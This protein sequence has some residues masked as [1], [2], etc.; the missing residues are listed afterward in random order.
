[1]ED[2]NKHSTTDQRNNGVVKDGHPIFYKVDVVV[3]SFVIIMN[4]LEIF[5]LKCLKKKLRIYE[6]FLL[7][8][9]CSDLLFGFTYLS[10]GSEGGALSSLFSDANTVAAITQS[11]FLL[12]LL[13]SIF[14]LNAIALDRLWA[15]C[16]PI[17]HNVIV[18]KPRVRIF[19]GFVWMGCAILISCLVTVTLY[20]NTFDIPVEAPVTVNGTKDNHNTTSKL[21][22]MSS[23]NSSQ[24]I[25]QRTIDSDSEDFN[26]STSSFR[27]KNNGFKMIF[28]NEMQNACSYAVIIS[29]VLLFLT[30]GYII[31]YIRSI[32]RNLGESTKKVDFSKHKKVLVVCLLIALSFLALTLPF[33]I[34]R[35][36][37][38]G[39]DPW[40]SWLLLLNSGTN[41]VVY[42]ARGDY[43]LRCGGRHLKNC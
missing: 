36:T 18:T 41:S 6:T 25:S 22:N 14:H 17:K 34:Y 42:I 30:Y 12:F 15:I 27:E 37:T 7:S 29:D 21:E 13:I 40:V 43:K 1:M 38:N 28:A 35:W 24:Y 8:L 2:N 4:L 10:I 3:G 16:K 20:T 39:N 26:I 33:P 23:G 9:S 19:L 5:I 32:Q 11:A 31:Y